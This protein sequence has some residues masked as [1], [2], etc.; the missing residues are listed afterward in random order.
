MNN[1]L[2]LAIL[3]FALLLN[4][5]SPLFA[6]IAPR[7][8][9]PASSQELVVELSPFTV[10]TSRDTGYAAENT[11]AG[12]RLN[13]RLRRLQPM[14]ACLFG[15][16]PALA[17]FRPIRVPQINRAF[18]RQKGQKFRRTS[19]GIGHIADKMGRKLGTLRRRQRNSLLEIGGVSR[20]K[21]LSLRHRAPPHLR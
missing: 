12:S 13:A 7:A 6:Q 10:D 20:K 11:L 5:G 14:K 17:R 16:D 19:P 1:K 18:E 21:M 2:R 15:N 3:P 8:L 4:T 9:S